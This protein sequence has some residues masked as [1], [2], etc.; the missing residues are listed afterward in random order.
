MSLR[1]ARHPSPLHELHD[2]Q[3][4]VLI[5]DRVNTQS[6]NATMIKAGLSG[7]ST[8]LESHSIAKPAHDKVF[9]NTDPLTATTALRLGRQV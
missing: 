1:E 8:E 5:R 3:H 9:D 6:V 2:K 7:N 4:C